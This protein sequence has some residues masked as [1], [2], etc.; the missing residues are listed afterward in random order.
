MKIAD[1]P[2]QE[3]W[4]FPCGGS[5]ISVSATPNCSFIAAASVDHNLYLIHGDGRPAWEKPAKLD[6]EVWATAI[7]LDGRLIAG[8]TANKKPADGSVYVFDRTQNLIWSET[9]G[10]PVWGVSLSGDGQYLAVSCWNN[11]VYKFVRRGER[12]ELEHERELP[13]GFGLYGIRLTE[14][15]STCVVCSYNTGLFILDENWSIRGQV[16]QQ[17]GLY[18]VCIAD[19]NGSLVAGL[20][21]GAAL[22]VSPID[23]GRPPEGF[24]LPR[25]TS[26]PIC[27]VAVSDD[28]KVL[29]LGGFD[30]HLYLISSRGQRLWTYETNG[31]V[32]SVAMSRDGRLI[33]VG[34]GDNSVRLLLNH[35]TSAAI[36]EMHAVE[37]AIER[38]HERNAWPEI[39]LVFDTLI[40]LYLRYGI[41]EYGVSRLTELKALLP[42]YLIRDYLR[43]FLEA[44]ISANPDHYYSHYELGNVLCEAKSFYEA[45]H[46]YQVA[47]NE[48]KYRARALEGAAKCFSALKLLT[49]SFSCYRRAHEQQLDSDAKRVLYNLARSYEDLG[50]WQEAIR[51]YELLI[52]WDA[53]YRD[54]WSRLQTL[55]ALSQPGYTESNSFRIDDTEISSNLL[56]PDTPRKH[57]VDDTLLPIITAR[58]SEV[59]M[60]PQLRRKM[61]AVISEL[62]S[63][64]IFMRGITRSGLD[65][66]T[67]M[68]LKYEYLHP[69]DELKKFLETVHMLCAIE[70][71]SIHTALDIGTATGRYPMLLRAKAIKTY[72]IDKE[73]RAVSYACKKKG[74]CDWPQFIVGDATELPI[75]SGMFDL[76]TCMMG[77]FAHIPSQQQ[78]KTV[79]EIAR[80]LRPGGLAIIST[81]DVEC[82]HL[83]FLSMY[84][85]TQKEM[86]RRTSPRSE[87]LHDLFKRHGLEKVSLTPF[88]ILPQVIV[89]DLGLQKLNMSGLRMAADID[90]AMR[91]TYPDRHGEMYLT[92][93]RKCPE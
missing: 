50:E 91:A 9:M 34:S 32:W 36:S 13:S 45:A 70:G 22:I 21:E 59:L 63:D 12:Y 80:V 71:M 54:A 18:K 57:E 46:H 5:I 75:R 93:A 41:V 2:F 39:E 40:D 27:G 56:G 73:H 15:G 92:V 19:H 90:I 3:L 30:G 11:R 84:N 88:C 10:A 55:T 4:R 60:E 78:G 35:S 66:T 61:E 17:T 72:G 7:S 37:D 65:Y 68:Y 64:E 14:D 53:Q 51:H 43:R 87:D 85:E 1:K 83:A 23:G 76:V 28:G 67:E 8:G 25:L 82:E 33:C 86:M 52:S 77:T 26:R 62:T 24:K 38:C 44:D 6:N 69:E 74:H 16:P 89:Y 79:C 20:R 48:S 31:E 29:S 47:A 42:T 81:W 58:S 49:A